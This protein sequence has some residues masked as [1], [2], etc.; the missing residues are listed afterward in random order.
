MHAVRA[1]LVRGDLARKSFDTRLV[2]SQARHQ[3][4]SM[5]R[6]D[7]ASPV[8]DHGTSDSDWHSRRFHFF[9][10]ILLAIDRIQPHDSCARPDDEYW[11]AS[12]LDQNRRRILC[13]IVERLPNLVT[14]EFV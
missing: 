3:G 11:F 5:K 7:Q 4:P 12:L 10:P 14:C 8:I 6:G 1:L 9:A 13:R 2:G